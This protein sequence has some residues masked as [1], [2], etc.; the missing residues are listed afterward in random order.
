MISRLERNATWKLEQFRWQSSK[1]RFLIEPPFTSFDGDPNM[2]CNSAAFHIAQ[3]GPWVEYAVD[4]NLLFPFFPAEIT[5]SSLQSEMTFYSID[6]ASIK[7]ATS[8]RFWN[9]HRPRLPYR[10]GWNLSQTIYLLNRRN[11]RV[12]NYSPICRIPIIAYWF[13]IQ[14]WVN[15]RWFKTK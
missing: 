13:A 6:Q 8:T 11:S 3:P 7:W 10:I 14:R 12:F 4:C 1:F 15:S 2:G 5:A 9:D